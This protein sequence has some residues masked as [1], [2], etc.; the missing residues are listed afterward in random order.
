LITPSANWT[1]AATG[2]VYEPVV[3]IDIDGLQISASD[4]F[5]TTGEFSGIT[6]AYKRTLTHVA[7]ADIFKVDMLNGSIENGEFAFDVL[8]KD[9]EFTLLLNNYSMNERTVVV[10][11]GFPTLVLGDFITLPN[12]VITSVQL[13]ADLITYHVVAAIPIFK[14]FRDMFRQQ[15]LTTLTSRSV[16]VLTG[17]IDPTASNFVVG[18]GT[19]FTSEL[20]VGDFILVSTELREVSQIA[21]NTNLTVSVPFSNNGND[22]SPEKWSKD[23]TSSQTILQVVD[24][25]KFHTSTELNF[26]QNAYAIIANNEVVFV[27][28]STSTTLT[29]ERG[30]L[31][32][33]A[34]AH[35]EGD[36]IVQVIFA[37]SSVYGSPGENIL[38]LLTSTNGGSNGDYDQGIEG[39]GGDLDI[40]LIDDDDIIRRYLEKYVAGPGAVGFGVSSMFAFYFDKPM[41]V[42]KMLED[43]F[44]KMSTPLI[45]KITSSGKFTIFMP[46]PI[47][48]TAVVGTLTE[49]HIISIVANI[50]EDEIINRARINF[51]GFPSQNEELWE[52]VVIKNTDSVTTYGAKPIY[53]I[54]YPPGAVPISLSGRAGF[55][56]QYIVMLWRLLA[57]FGR[58]N[59]EFTVEVEWGSQ[60][61]EIGD[62]VGLTHTGFPDWNNTGRGISGLSGYVISKK[63]SLTGMGSLVYVIKCFDAFALND[64]PITSI[65]RKSVV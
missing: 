45:P 29:V 9:N 65:D 35:F 15:P 55:I 59:V 26:A 63:F 17:S 8:D 5:F 24:T 40:S 10:K 64:D 49:D 13:D 11:V 39:L 4:V 6:S 62:L 33:Q 57:L 47:V 25:T 19:L 41:R 14:V 36:P 44:F 52:E 37:S 48:E 12:A 22:T 54:S 43:T 30:V 34:R 56:E 28:G 27:T 51:N 58:K 38:R 18:V 21:D 7:D 61:F 16:S 23:T 2:N 1:T 32:T 60:L 46:D 42:E 20:V 31:G 3:V 50:R 53:E